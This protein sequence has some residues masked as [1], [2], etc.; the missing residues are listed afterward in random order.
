MSILNQIRN[1]NKVHVQSGTVE[2]SV[3]GISSGS[4]NSF[5]GRDSLVWR[6]DSITGGFSDAEFTVNATGTSPG[7]VGLMTRHASIP[8]DITTAMFNIIYERER[9]A[10]SGGGLKISYT[11]PALANGDYV[12]NLYFCNYYAAT[13][14]VGDRFF[15]VDVDGVRVETDLDLVATYGHRVA[16]MLSYPVTLTDG[17]LNVDIVNGSAD[18]A[19]INGIEIR[20]V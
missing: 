18:N 1:Q 3:L 15:H 17:L 13:D 12:V 19:I 2:T 5:T 4:T 7:T 9:Y 10:T 20:E 14:Q 6:S 11:F 8:A 16:V